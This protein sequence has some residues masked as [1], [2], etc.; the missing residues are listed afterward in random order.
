MST[1]QIASIFGT[2]LSSAYN[3]LRGDLGVPQTA[4]ETIDKLV[5]KI[6]TSAAVEDRRTAV[7]G[8]KGLSRDWKEDV[9]RH[10]FLQNPK[11]IHSVVSLISVSTSF[12]PRFYSLQFLSQLLTARTSVAQSHIMSAPPPG[13]DGILAVLDSTTS[14]VPSTI[15]GGAVEMLR[16]EA[17]LLLPVL[18][19]GNQDLQKIVAF[20]GAFEKLF[21][22]IEQE[23]GVDGGIVVHDSLTALGTLLRFNVSNQNYFRELTLIPQIPAILG[24]PSGILADVQTPDSFALQYWPEQKVHNTGLVLGLIRMLVGGPGGGN[25]NA[26]VPSGVTRCLLELSLA[27]NAPPSIKTQC[28]LTLMP[29][30]TASPHNQDFLTSLQLS[31]LLAVHADMDHPNGGFVRMEPKP[32]VVALVGSIVEGDPANGNHSL[33]GRVEGVNLFEAYVSDNDEARIGILSSLIA[34]GENLADQT[35]SAGSL[36][37][38]GILELPHTSLS[39]EFDPYRPLFASLLLSHIIRNSEHAK[40]LAREITFPSGDADPDSTVNSEEDRILFIQLVVGNL[41]L[42]QRE[43]QECVNQAAKEGQVETMKQAEGWTRVMVGYL[44]LLC[45]WLWDSPKS[46]SDFLSESN[47]LQALIQP[48]TQNT[49]I[50]PLVQGLSAFLLGVC[51]EFNREPGEITRATLH[52]ILHSRIGPDQ[53]VSR[54]ARLR[55]DSRFRAVQ[56]EG[57]EVEGIVENEEENAQGEG[58]WFD[59]AFVDFWK[60]HYYTIQRA[61]AI[62][63]DAVRPTTTTSDHSETTSIILTL[64]SKL[65]AQTDEV[66]QLQTKLEVVNKESKAEKEQLAGEVEELGKQVASMTGDL[67]EKT[68]VIEKLQEDLSTLQEQYDKLKENAGTAELKLKELVSVREELNLIKA[69]HEKTLSE[70]GL[71]RMSAKGRE[72]KFQDLEVKIKRL[73]EELAAEVSAR[74][75]A[76]LAQ[77]AQSAPNPEDNTRI[78]QLQKAEDNLEKE[79]KDWTSKEATLN[80]QLKTQQNQVEQLQSRNNAAQKEAEESQLKTSE[81]EKKIVELE[82]KLKDAEEKLA[83][84]PSST[85]A[86]TPEPGQGVSGKQAKKRAA[87]LDVKVKELEAT[88]A[89][90]KSKREEE[91]KEHEDLLV[92]LDEL[93]AKRQ[94]D[95]TLMKEKGLDVSEDEE[96]ADDE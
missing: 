26:M 84:A 64:R 89:K 67:Q 44:S 54:M 30:L 85:I 80:L 42:A 33:R 35:A 87:E 17:L 57:F 77:T 92:L 93:S 74:Q 38:S 27:S 23:G 6:Q 96:E 37:L 75:A 19:Q 52:P 29:I 31:P 15:G 48:I 25:Q 3:Q 22:I 90:E 47:N 73:E 94:R 79:R 5:D 59:W 51:Y 24:F 83:A 62:D 46:V 39:P 12:Y 4:T 78:E 69:E 66:I 82:K 11:P 41:I 70:L 20:S 18:L 86:S 13:I 32:A 91:Y 43:Q 53:F 40:K 7:F 71:A 49:S 58:I 28:L 61:I 72:N 10:A 95:K 50:D 9:G 63:P 88:L 65:K 56:P 60:N 21:R 55:E 1:N 36:I 81:F 16:N 68:L 14:S 34:S 8:L 2:K 45:T 76:E